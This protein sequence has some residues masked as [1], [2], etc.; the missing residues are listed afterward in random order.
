MPLTLMV[1]YF[2]YDYTGN[3]SITNKQTYNRNH[4]CFYRQTNRH[5]IPIQCVSSNNPNAVCIFTTADE[6][7]DFDRNLC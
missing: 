4:M 2:K 3:H 6:L 7:G 5:A 1:R